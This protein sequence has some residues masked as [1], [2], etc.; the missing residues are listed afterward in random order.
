MIPNPSYDDLTEKE[1]QILAL[2]VQDDSRSVRYIADTLNISANYIYTLIRQMKLKLGVQNTAALIRRAIQEGVIS[3]DGNLMTKSQPRQAYS[4][5]SQAVE[6]ATDIPDVDEGAGHAQT[7]KSA[8]KST[9]H[10]AEVVPENPHTDKHAG[11][12]QPV[13]YTVNSTLQ[14]PLK[15]RAIVDWLTANPDK[16]GLTALIASAIQEGVISPPPAKE[17]LIIDWLNANPDKAHLSS[18]KIAALIGD[19]SHTLV[20]QARCRISLSRSNSLDSTEG[21]NIP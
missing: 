20:N 17:R 8:V 19:V 21:K 7:V 4:N 16:A 3:P 13:K 11:F 1:R 15:Q 2:M 18:R 14:S 9:L 5:V 12:A 10:A 6:N